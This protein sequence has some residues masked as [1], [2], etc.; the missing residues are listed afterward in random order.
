MKLLKNDL[1]MFK[2]IED[3]S[4]YFLEQY[5]NAIVTVTFVDELDDDLTYHVTFPDASFG[6]IWLSEKE[7]ELM[8]TT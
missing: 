8:F 5:H 1:A 6:A 3:T 7:L 4:P 2:Y